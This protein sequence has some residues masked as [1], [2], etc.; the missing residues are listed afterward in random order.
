M[1]DG[2]IQNVGLTETMYYSQLGR[3]ENIIIELE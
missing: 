1:V 2:F 3:P